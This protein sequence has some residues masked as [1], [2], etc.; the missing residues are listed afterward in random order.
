MPLFFR[1]KT[2]RE[3][4]HDQ[5]RVRRRSNTAGRAVASNKLQAWGLPESDDTPLSKDQ[6]LARL[7]FWSQSQIFWRDSVTSSNKSESP[8]SSSSSSPETDDSLPGDR[9][10]LRM[11]TRSVGKERGSDLASRGHNILWTPSVSKV[12]TTMGVFDSQSERVRSKIDHL[13]GKVCDRKDATDLRDRL[14]EI[15]LV[16]TSVR[17]F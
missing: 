3:E 1:S 12:S 13:M 17:K 2:V 8:S 6:A 16:E 7:S 4:D 9:A 5:R 14:E 10:L 11:R 15:M